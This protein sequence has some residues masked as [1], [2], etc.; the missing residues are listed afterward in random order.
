M[1]FWT[2]QFLYRLGGN[3]GLTFIAP[4]SGANILHVEIYASVFLSLISTAIV[5]AAVIF[6]RMEKVGNTKSSQ[7]EGA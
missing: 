6:R 3:A 1:N 5:G 4:F 7:E 2:R